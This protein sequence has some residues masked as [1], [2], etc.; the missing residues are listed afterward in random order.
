MLIVVL[1]AASSAPGQ[2]PPRAAT[3]LEIQSRIQRSTE[4][5]R[6]ALQSLSAADQADRLLGNAYAEL[7]GA[8]SAIVINAS[9][10]KFPDPIVDINT[11]RADR[12]L[13][14]LLAARDAIRTNQR[15]PA[16]APDRETGASAGARP[17]L[18]VVRT[19]I[20]E[21]LRLTSSIVVY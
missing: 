19:H 7:Q 1:T 9:G 13:S 10:A 18:D 2:S 16:P 17:Y 5:Q 11:N 15:N 8:R 6:Q 20:E 4:L 3:S 21:A 14:L 12:A